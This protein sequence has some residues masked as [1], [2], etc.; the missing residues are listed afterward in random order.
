M[1]FKLVIKQQ[2]Q[3]RIKNVLQ[4]GTILFLP[5]F[6]RLYRHQNQIAIER[7]IEYLKTKP[8]YM[9]DYDDIRNTLG[10]G[11]KNFTKLLRTNDMQKIVDSEV[12]A[13]YRTFYPNAPPEEYNFKSRNIEKTLNAV[14]LIQPDVVVYDI[15]SKDKD[16]ELKEKEDSGF[17]DNKNELINVP[18]L[19]QAYDLIKDSKGEGL[20]QTELGNILGLSK[21][22]SRSIIRNLERCKYIVSFSKDVG[23]QRV[24]K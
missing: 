20:T 3:M 1:K 17:L 16:E 22:N 15:F 9:A 11:G 23:R 8:N 14:K 4:T 13:P 2:F 24:N 10:L 6:F 21:L 7:V 5:K 19:K 18:L 12:K